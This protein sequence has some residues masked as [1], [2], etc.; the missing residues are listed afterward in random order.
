MCNRKKYDHKYM[1]GHWPK[2]VD[3][4]EPSVILWQNLHYG[5]CSR[6]WRSLA[7]GFLSVLIMCI[8]LAGIVIAKYY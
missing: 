4:Y 2:L 5:V 8:A 6:F 3:A 7:T 1:K